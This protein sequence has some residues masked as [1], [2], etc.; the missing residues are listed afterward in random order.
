M[1][2]IMIKGGVWR[3]TED[4][5]LKAAVMKYGLNQWSR[6]ASLLHRKSSKQCKARWYEWLDPSIKKTEWSR[7]EEEKLLHLAKLMP[8][9]WRT[10]AP[11]VGRTAA[12]CLEHYDMM[13]NKINNEEGDDLH[14]LKPGEIDPA[15]ETKPARP[16]PIDM[17]EDEIEMLSE[18]RAR[19][20]NTQGKKAKRKAREKQLEEARRLASLQKRRELKAAGIQ[21]KKKRKKRGRIDYNAEIPF[22]QEPKAGF[23]DTSEEVVINDNPNFRR[24]RQD[25]LD[26]LTRRE[27]EERALKKDKQ[28]LKDKDVAQLLSNQNKP[29]AAKRSKLV[30]PAPQITDQEFE[31][32]IKVGQQTQM[33][34]FGQGD[35]L[36]SDYSEAYLSQRSMH[37][38]TPMAQ[39]D[40]IKQDTL[41]L[42]QMAN[43]DN[44]LKGGMNTPMQIDFS[45]RKS[46]EQLN[47]LQTPNTVFTTP[48]IMSSAHNNPLQTPGVQTPGSSISATPGATPVHDKLSIN[49]YDETPIDVKAS[50]DRIK[51]ML[52]ELPMPKNDFE[53][54]LDTDTEEQK[55]DSDNEDA[56]TMEVEDAA[57]IEAQKQQYLEDLKQEKLSKRHTALKKDLPRPTVVVETILRSNTSQLNDMQQAEEI[58]KKEMLSMLH[59]DAMNYPATNQVPGAKN[60]KA[61]SMATHVQYL[62]RHGY[63]ELDS[64]DFNESQQLIQKEMDDLDEKQEMSMDVFNQ[65]KRDRFIYLPTE[66]KYTDKRNA[67]KKERIE[68]LEHQLNNNREHM[69][70]GARAASKVEK[71]LKIMTK[72]L[73]QRNNMLVK[74]IA[75][76]ND[77][78]EEEKIKLNTFEQLLKCEQVAV[79]NRQKSLSSQLE[80]QMKREGELQLK[81]GKLLEKLS[82]FAKVNGSN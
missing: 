74:Q 34:A 55:K 24:L 17:D 59:Y 33:I 14:K 80:L 56:E 11:I 65:V 81:Y 61:S 28:K 20:A 71:K 75:E 67:S 4:E 64:K 66:K 25:H 53:I 40:H 54:V 73:Q 42:M 9:Q 36:V 41:A 26:N 79:E 21:P 35:D 29:P 46:K 69:K 72:G 47:E 1:P 58:I 2:R 22:A 32:V 18:A 76:Y 82:K 27:Q 23:H 19:L 6:I 38:R 60:K 8:T 10:I 52:N 5:I 44:P 57:D 13:I 39:E 43:V 51:S 31:E 3:N 45:G 62:S 68:S 49:R 50:K 12:Q 37:T 48:A 7:E 30:L 70:V 77:Q 15:P 16:D 63:Q 78:L